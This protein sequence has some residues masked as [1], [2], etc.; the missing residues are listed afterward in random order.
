M[1]RKACMGDRSSLVLLVLVWLGV[2]G[3][4][5]LLVAARFGPLTA[6]AVAGPSTAVL[7]TVYGVRR[8]RW[9]RRFRREGAAVVAGFESLL[10][11]PDDHAE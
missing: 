7:A 2:G 6:L 4:A 10:R 5:S 11:R 1:W 9:T 8:F 3:L